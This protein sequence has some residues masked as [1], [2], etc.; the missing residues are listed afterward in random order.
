[1]SRMRYVF[2]MRRNGD[3]GRARHCR[4]GY[5]FDAAHVLVS[6]G[7]L[8][9]ADGDCSSLVWPNRTPFCVRIQE[10][11]EVVSL[12]DDAFTS[13]APEVEASR[14]LRRMLSRSVVAL[15]LVADPVVVFSEL[16]VSRC[17][18]ECGV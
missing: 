2:R 12:V 14:A 7:S 15:T 16:R 10:H 5:R 3:T 4:D 8:A 11:S 1:M 13:P 9:P 17:G 18:A 6:Y